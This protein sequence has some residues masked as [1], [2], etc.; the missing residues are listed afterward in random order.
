[1]KKWLQNEVNFENMTGKWHWNYKNDLKLKNNTKWRKMHYKIT[2]FGA[3][4]PYPRLIY[5]IPSSISQGN[6]GPDYDIETYHL[7]QYFYPLKMLHK[8]D[9]ETSVPSEK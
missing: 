8:D 5:W 9:N 6:P 3:C 2:I 4:A 7:T 1:M